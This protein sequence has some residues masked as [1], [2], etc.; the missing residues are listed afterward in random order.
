[1]EIEEVTTLE[2]ASVPPFNPGNHFLDDNG[3][4]RPNT[5]IFR[6]YDDADS[7]A[8]TGEKPST[9]LRNYVLYRQQGRCAVCRIPEWATSK[10]LQLHRKEPKGLYSIYNVVALC[11]RCHSDEHVRLKAAQA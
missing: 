5:G 8:N 7:K 9:T 6:P 1:M 4:F 2:I 11:T 10:R 3:V